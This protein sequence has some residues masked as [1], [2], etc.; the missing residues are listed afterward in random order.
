MSAANFFDTNIALYLLSG[1]ATKADR[2][3]RLLAKGGTISVQVL[4]EFVAVAR[5][6]YDVPWAA[7]EDTLAALRHVCR[8]EPLGI[9]VHESAVAL[10]K[11][12]RVPIYDA[13]IVAAAMQAGCTTLYSEDFQS[14]RKF[15][16]LQVINPFVA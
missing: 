16:S 8:V 2:A 15:G 14:N 5:R 13:C 12:H 11:R 1:D 4:N 9:E 3:E 7:V 6:K 10:C